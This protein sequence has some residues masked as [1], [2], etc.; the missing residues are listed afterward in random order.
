M[1]LRSKEFLSR[2]SH[3]LMTSQQMRVSVEQMRGSVEQMRV[4]EEEEQHRH[5]RFPMNEPVLI[6]MVVLVLHASD[7]VEFLR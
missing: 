1:S 2:Y 7:W 6:S 3:V 4:L 5:S